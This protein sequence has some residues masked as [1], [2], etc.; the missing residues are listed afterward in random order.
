MRDLTVS[1]AIQHMYIAITAMI[2]NIVLLLVFISQTS[3]QKRGSAPFRRLTGITLIANLLSMIA[4][5]MMNVMLDI[6]IALA[7]L[8]QLASYLLNIYVSYF[9]AMYVESLTNLDESS[10]RR[11]HIL[12]LAIMIFMTCALAAYYVWSLPRLNIPG[13]NP[14]ATGWFRL[15]AGFAAEFYYLFYALSFLIIKTEMGLRVKRSLPWAFILTVSTLVFQA[16]NGTRPLLNYLGPTLGLIVFYFTAETSDYMDL[17]RTTKELEEET[18]RAN[19]LQAFSGKVTAQCRVLLGMNDLILRDTAE[20]KISLYARNIERTARDLLEMADE[21]PLRGREVFQEAAPAAADEAQDASA[22]TADEG[23]TQKLSLTERIIQLGRYGATKEE[24]DG[25]RERILRWN[26]KT[27]RIILALAFFGFIIAYLAT[28]ILNTMQEFRPVFIIFFLVTSVFYFPLILAPARFKKYATVMAYAGM[29]IIL[30]F[31]MVTGTMHETE[32]AIDYPIMM[33]WLSLCIVDNAWR[34]TGVIAV[35]DTICFYL[36]YLTKTPEIAQRDTYNILIYSILVVIGHIL[37]QRNRFNELMNAGRYEAVQAELISTMDRLKDATERAT[38]ASHSKSDFLANMSHEIRTPINAVL[39][40]NEMILRE[41]TDERIR[42]YAHNVD[43]AGKNLLSIINDI[44]D[45]SK[46]EAG[47][48]EI[49]QAEYR[50]SSV[51][52]DVS[53]MIL[54][55]AKSK[56]LSFIV[57]VDETLPDALY[58]DEVRVRQVITN[59]LNNAVKYTN[60]GSVTLTIRGERVAQET[61]EGAAQVHSGLVGQINLIVSVSDTGIGIKEEDRQKLFTKFERVDLEQTNTIEGTGLG[62]AITQNLLALMHGDV[63]VESVYGEGS[64]FTLRIPQGIV[65]EGA[66]GDFHQ[67]FEESFR[68]QKKYKE[69]FRAP[70]ARI[71]VVDDTQMNLVVIKGLLK[72]TEIKLDTATGGA[73]ALDMTMD[74]PY[75]LI[76]MDQR[77]P[78]MSGAETLQHLRAQTGGCNHETQVICLT[79]D[80]VQGARERYLEQGFGDYLSKPVEGDALEAMLMRHLPTEKVV[81][82]LVE[83]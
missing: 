50:L 6:P 7:L 49:A 68:A 76:L 29:I 2:F 55:R 83:T 4:F 5:F 36:L 77:M 46:I 66:I 13:R 23:K 35:M 71:L 61:E 37:L 10:R 72:K 44:L 8:S 42:M 34:M 47:K 27:S 74:T 25:C 60:E 40:M 58:G 80:A 56:D 12:N 59:I 33:V 75:D 64:T 51:L 69:T 78:H 45:F 3:G 67:R 70:D 65:A 57:N 22:Q 79:A 62:L 26:E 15:F 14:Y 63:Y 82:M 18:R 9:F 11:W 73:Q 31:A 43:N 41:S 81:T 53:N 19:L 38:K 52:N 1:G 21:L 48:M 16:V 28:G 17:M 30:S 39:G 32:R 24:Y 54:F 20:E